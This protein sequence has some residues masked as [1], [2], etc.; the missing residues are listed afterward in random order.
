MLTLTIEKRDLKAKLGD[1]RSTGKI[2]AVFYG[3]K[4]ESTP[5]AMSEVDFMKTWRQ[6]G[7]SSIIVLKGVGE[8]HE[9]L[10]HDIDLDPVTGKVRHA[11]FYVI[12]K[13]K[14][15]KVAIPIEFTGT[16]PAIKEL[17]GILVKVLHEVEIEALPKDLPHTL[18][19]DVS[20]LV[21]FDTQIK[22]SDIKLPAGVTLE[23]DPEEVVALVS[24]PKEEVEETV[25]AD[26][27]TIEVVGAKGK[28]E[29]E[30]DASSGSLAAE[31]S[32]KA[33]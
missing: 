29:D 4:E 24:K 26:L 20:G 15:L 31:A 25:P 27:S 8:E 1:I 3:R 10:I 16:A 14:K 12:E 19:V 9:A 13:G 21:D 18:T 30:G 32:T 23:I 6:A 5:I 33:K 28:A 17:G 11:D 2:P 7:E 22:A